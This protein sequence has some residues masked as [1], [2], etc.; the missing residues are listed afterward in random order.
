MIGSL[1]LATVPIALL[2]VQVELSHKKNGWIGLII[3]ALSFAFSFL[4]PI[5]MYRF[6]QAV[7][8]VQ[9]ISMNRMLLLS[10]AF[11]NIPTLICVLMYCHG[12]RQVYNEKK[13]RKEREQRLH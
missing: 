6:V 8:E 2:I 13:Q 3:P 5:S 4:Y 9:A 10:F 11:A 12:R 7:S 1:L